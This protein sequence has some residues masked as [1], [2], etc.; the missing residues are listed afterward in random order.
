MVVAD[1]LRL[2][3][4][5]DNAKVPPTVIVRAA[6]S[7]PIRVPPLWVKLPVMA[8]LL[9]PVLPR[10]IDP[11]PV[12]ISVKFPRIVPSPVVGVRASDVW[13]VW[14]GEFQV[15]LPKLWSS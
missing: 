10:A 13:T 2:N 7:D 11:E 12:L 5:P 14:P 9:V 8:T 4:P 3:V 6:D 15:T 1:E